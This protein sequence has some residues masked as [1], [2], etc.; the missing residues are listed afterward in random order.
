MR[1]GPVDHAR[2]FVHIDLGVRR[3]R[4]LLH[5]QPQAIG[6]GQA[7]DDADRVTALQHLRGL[8]HLRPHG[9]QL[10]AHVDGDDLL[11]I[12]AQSLQPIQDRIQVSRPHL[13]Q[14]VRIVPA[15]FLNLFK[16]H[17]G[18]ELFRLFVQRGADLN[19][20][21]NYLDLVPRPNFRREV[22]VAVGDDAYFAHSAVV[23]SRVDS[24]MIPVVSI[25]F[26]PA[27]GQIPAPIQRPQRTRC[28][29]G[30]SPCPAT[31]RAANHAPF[32]TSA[33]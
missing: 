6:R 24:C 27:I 19:A 8:A 9:A 29:Y 32:S 10:A 7:V 14:Q 12:G 15:R 13:R 30:P 31:A 22:C 23:P 11:G 18:A 25:T 33:F 21:G 20:V 3:F 4:G 17:I 1:D 2:H 26:S 16:H 28:G 5:E